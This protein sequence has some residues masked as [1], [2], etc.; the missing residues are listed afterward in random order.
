MWC[1]EA[2]CLC[3]S[4]PS[5]LF[6][7]IETQ[8]ERRNLGVESQF[9]RSAPSAFSQAAVFEAQHSHLAPSVQATPPAFCTLCTGYEQ[10]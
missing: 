1:F 2:E 6:Q 8:V 4:P 7:A 3:Q 5:A 9:P 10:A